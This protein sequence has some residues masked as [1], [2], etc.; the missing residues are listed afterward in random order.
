MEDHDDFAFEPTPGLPEKLPEG[1]NLLWQ[2]SPDWRALA[3]SAFHVRKVALYFALLLAWTM[4][5]DM[6][7]GAPMADMA[8][9]ALWLLASGAIAVGILSGLV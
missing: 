9:S 6:M 7:D 8:M 2:G 3:R 4:A 5:T 1:E